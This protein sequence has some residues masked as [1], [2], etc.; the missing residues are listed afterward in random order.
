M[1]PVRLRTQTMWEAVSDGR[2]FRGLFSIVGRPV[3]H[4]PKLLS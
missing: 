3:S 4:I 2:P 1:K